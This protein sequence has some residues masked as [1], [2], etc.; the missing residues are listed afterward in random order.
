MKVFC[1]NTHFRVNISTL[2]FRCPALRRMFVQTS[3]AAAESPNGF[4]R[5]LSSDTPQDFSTLLK[6]IYLQGSLLRTRAAGSLY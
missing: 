6:T 5:I 2:P 3:L 4:P 1:E